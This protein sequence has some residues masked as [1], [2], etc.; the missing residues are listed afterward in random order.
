MTMP[1]VELAWLLRRA[2]NWGAEITPKPRTKLERAQENMKVGIKAM[3]R[4]SN[5]L[6]EA[7]ED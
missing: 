1:I 7:E 5:P 2:V 3:A 4:K 6:L